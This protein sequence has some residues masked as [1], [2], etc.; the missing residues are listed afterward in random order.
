[1]QEKGKGREG[2]GKKRDANELTLYDKL[3][4]FLVKT[5]I[6]LPTF[7]YICEIRMQKHFHE[8]VSKVLCL[9]F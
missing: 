7:L 1:M 6:C 8:N 4:Y 9:S 3:T 2:K 5:P